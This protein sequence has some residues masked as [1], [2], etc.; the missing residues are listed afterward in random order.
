[1]C[2]LSSQIDNLWSTIDDVRS[3]VENIDTTVH[4]DTYDFEKSVDLLN[5]KFDLLAEMIFKLNGYDVYRKDKKDKRVNHR[6]TADE[7]ASA[8][9][10]H[11]GTNWGESK[12]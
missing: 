10:V 6:M 8:F 11:V 2:D 1:M 4:V 9:D 7:L 5:R 3:R 12:L